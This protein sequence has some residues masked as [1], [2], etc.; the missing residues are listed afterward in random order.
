MAQTGKGSGAAVSD[1]TGKTLANLEDICQYHGWQDRT[2]AGEAQL[3]NFINDTLQ[4]LSNLAPW[5]EYH[6]IDGAQSFVRATDTIESITGDGS[7]VTVTLTSHTIE[8]NDIG[9]ITSTTNYNVSNKI[10]TDAGANSVTYED[11]C[12]AAEETSGTITTGDQKILG[13]TRIERI[14]AVLRTGRQAPLD[15]ISIDEWLHKKRYLAATGPPTEYAIRKYNA[16]GLP[17]LIMCVYPTP[18]SSAT[19]YYTYKRYPAFLSNDSDKTDWPTTRIWLLTEAL[20]TRLNSKD[21]DASGMAL[22]GSEFMS[23][24]NLAFGHSRTSYMPVVAKP[25]LVIG[26][27]KWGVKDLNRHNITITS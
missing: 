21:K 1:V 13:D 8:T 12:A 27:G 20:R 11:D 9:D 25:L 26:A 17:K 19:L 14:G 2:T 3:D 4:L 23:K 24:V 22:Y 6:R 15:E 10:L 18:T 16:S 7:T 5:P